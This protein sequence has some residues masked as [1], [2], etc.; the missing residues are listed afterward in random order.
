M[1]ELKINGKIKMIGEIQQFDS[2][3]KKVE[4]V[5]TTLC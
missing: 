5:V 4:F 3:F 2:G 1:T